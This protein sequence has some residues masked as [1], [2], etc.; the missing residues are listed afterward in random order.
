MIGWHDGATPPVPARRPLLLG[1]GLRARAAP[2]SERPPGGGR[3]RDRGLHR[4]VHPGL[5][6]Q[7]RVRADDPATATALPG[8]GGDLGTVAARELVGDPGAVRGDGA[9]HHFAG[10][11]R[12]AP[13]DPADAAVVAFV[14]GAVLGPPDTVAAISIA[15]RLGLPR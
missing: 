1:R 8:G 5:R 9:G 10:R 12:D 13:A 15:R 6:P 11:I 4:A 3:R 2:G 14:L 7:A